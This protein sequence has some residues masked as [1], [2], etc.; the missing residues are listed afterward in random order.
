MSVPTTERGIRTLMQ[1][2]DSR[3]PVPNHSVE[4]DSVA[5]QHICVFCSCGWRSYRFAAEVNAVYQARDHLKLAAVGLGHC[6]RGT[7]E[8]HP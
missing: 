6:S 2:W 4:L 3:P 7:L 5:P 1:W 8:G